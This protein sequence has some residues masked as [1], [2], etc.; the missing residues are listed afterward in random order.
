MTETWVRAGEPLDP[1]AVFVRTQVFVEEQGFCHEF[2]E[3]D[4]RA[5]HLV[6]YDNGCPVATG[7]VFLAG[8]GAPVPG[9]CMIGRIAVVRS[10]RGSGTGRLV[11][12]RLLMRAGKLADCA[13]LDAQ[14]QAIPFYERLGFSV[15]DPT[16]EVHYDE[17][18]P[19]RWM[20]KQLK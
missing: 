3:I 12:E 13:L 16:G 4:A 5:D 8:D 9:A 15:L 10:H 18:C 7:R 1:G 19:H 2:D 11:M 6:L 17:H 14:V 20:V